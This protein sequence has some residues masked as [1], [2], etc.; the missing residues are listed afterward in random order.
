MASMAEARTRSH[1][2]IAWGITVVVLIGLVSGC[3]RPEPPRIAGD[4]LIIGDDRGG[5]RTLMLRPVAAG[6]LSS[7]FGWRQ[8]PFTGEQRQHQG[9]DYRAEAGEP[10]YAAGDGVVVAAGR[11]GGYGRYVRIRHDRTYETAYAHLSDH[12]ADLFVGAM[13]GQ[14][15]VIGFVGSTGRSTG[16]HLHYELLAD[17][18]PMDPLATV[19]AAPVDADA[20]DAT[21][22]GGD[23]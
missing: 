17:G 4:H 10:V 7:R 6:Q 11:R 14:G 23:D 13:V 12:A 20:S 18:V 3:T 15:E 2:G 19:V 5:A 21:A 1:R 8:D 9:I 22:I 16:P